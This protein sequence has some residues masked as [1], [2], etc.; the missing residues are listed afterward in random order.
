MNTT[1]IRQ[2]GVHRVALL[3]LVLLVGALGGCQS[4]T[5]PV[6]ADGSAG[7]DGSGG[8][9][10]AAIDQF[11]PGTDAVPSPDLPPGCGSSWLDGSLSSPYFALGCP[12][13]DTCPITADITLQGKTGWFVPEGRGCTLPSGYLLSARV[14]LERRSTVTLALTTAVKMES[15]TSFRNLCQLRQCGAPQGNTAILDAGEHTV[16]VLTA[17]PADFELS[18]SILPSS[19]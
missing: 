8:D 11:M 14:V 16:E 5:R 15:E 13:S 17:A 2:F 4:S 19:E 10:V 18:I 3:A 7:V 6:S 9:L 1:A 12:P